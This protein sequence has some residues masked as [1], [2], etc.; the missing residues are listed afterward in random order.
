M[1]TEI[2]KRVLEY[3]P[4]NFI[5]SAVELG[6]C[7]GVYLSNTLE[8]EQQGWE[9]LCI[10][11]NPQ[12]YAELQKNRKLS[13]NYAVAAA[14][15]ENVPFHIYRFPYVTETGACDSHEAALSS[16]VPLEEV[17]AWIGTPISH[18]VA[19]IPVRTLDQC[20]AE[21]GMKS[22]HFLS[23]DVEGG[24]MDVL[25]GFSLD[26]WRPWIIVLE[27]HHIDDRF[28]NYLKPLY[29]LAFREIIHSWCNEYFILKDFNREAV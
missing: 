16:L 26:Y 4:P 1:T 28:V 22:V 11:P 14:P 15:A 21:A 3:L 2:T 18:R 24:E 20:M 29:N 7:D 5:G 13:L 6:A 27:N 12:Y 8:L 17:K 25:K 19:M 9:V 10:E 23:L